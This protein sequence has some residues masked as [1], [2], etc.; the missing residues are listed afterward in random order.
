MDAEV[1]GLVIYDSVLFDI[2]HHVSRWA[3]G[4]SAAFT[5]NA[6]EEAPV[7]SR[8][9][10]SG[11]YPGYPVGSLKASIS[12]DVERIGPKHMQI[13]INVDVPYA[14]YVIEGTGPFIFPV[15][16]KK[17]TLPANLGFSAKKLAVVKGQEAN[18]FMGR[19]ADR[20]A[21]THPSLRGFRNQV[22][23]QF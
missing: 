12:G 6:I 2:G 1:V 21:I 3:H 16:A 22:F 5:R 4:V 9:N 7:N 17:M 14:R 13:I 19:A 11:W 8:A 10:K 18:D 15:V 23:E 20:T